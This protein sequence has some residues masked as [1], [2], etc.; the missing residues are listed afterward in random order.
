[1]ARKKEEGGGG[2]PEWL[3]TFADLMSLLVCFFVLI[4]SFSTQ[5]K[6]KLEIV[7]G[8]MRDAFGI[9]DELR[10]AGFIE[11]D[12]VPDNPEAL[13]R[14]IVPKPL[15]YEQ[16][17]GSQPDSPADKQDAQ[18]PIR[19]AEFEK[20]AAS[21]RQALQD[22][23]EIA[24]LSKSIMFRMTDEGLHVELMDQ[25]GRPMFPATSREPYARFRD[26]LMHMAPV[27]RGLPHPIR[28]SG[29][30]A[31]SRPGAELALSPW[32]LSA[33]RAETTRRIL[34]SGGVREDQFDSIVGKAD[35]EPLFTNDPFLA[36]NRRITLLLLD[37]KPPISPDQMP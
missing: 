23:P 5:D 8:S 25:D 12:G 4:I 32:E 20:A 37:S 22:M 17:A 10:A 1:M 6:K 26:L 14:T 27:L 31:R 9:Q 35:I 16:P 15:N 28:I 30:V 13:H 7:A 3:V 18:N 34:I 21:L 33:D 11:R 24:E 19:D 2:A 36:S 29:H